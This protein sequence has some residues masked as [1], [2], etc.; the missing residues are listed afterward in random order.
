MGVGGRQLFY[1]FFGNFCG[2]VYS[3]GNSNSIQKL[4][5]TRTEVL[6]FFYTF[7]CAVS[8]YRFA[9]VCSHSFFML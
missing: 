7:I 6:F 8:G 2:R 1:Y 3:R 9:L 4:P 5:K